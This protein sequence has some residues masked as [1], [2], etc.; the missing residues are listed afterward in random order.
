M[1]PMFLGVKKQLEKNYEMI[2]SASD[3]VIRNISE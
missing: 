3:V 1:L 2:D